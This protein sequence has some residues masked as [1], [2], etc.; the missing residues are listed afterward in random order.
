MYKILLASP[1]IILFISCTPQ[2]NEEISSTTHITPSETSVPPK[3]NTPIITISPTFTINPPDQIIYSPNGEFIAEF[4]NAYSHPAYEQQVIKILSKDGN[5]FLEIP[6]Q[7]EVAMVDP[8]PGLKI[9]GWSKDSRYLYFYYAFSPDGGDR[10][11]WWDGFDLQR[12]NVQNGEIELVIS[13]EG[14][15]AFSFSPDETQI[16]FTRA[17]DFPSIIFVRDLTTGT[18][19]TAYV[20][21]ASKNYVRVGGIRWAKSGNEL[22]FHTEAKD[23]IVQT[24]YLNVSTMKQRLI[25]EYKLFT[26]LFQ[27]W[28]DDNSIEFLD[29]ENNANII[30]INPRNNEVIV[31]G[32]ITP[33]P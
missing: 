27:G 17:E 25:R 28:S 11:F 33:Q 31:V 2:T 29:L 23:Y 20:I 26:L 14:F 21:F 24:I 4:D 19:K 3:T 30:H 12:I 6:Y 10:A 15:V 9:Y 22:V 13:A 18:E 32:T 7:H 5:L 1:L 16:A 8:H